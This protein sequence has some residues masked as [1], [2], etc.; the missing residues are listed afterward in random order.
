MMLLMLERVPRRL[1]GEL[2]RWLLEPRA[3]LFIGN[4]SA[5][6]REKLW[7]MACLDSAGGSVFLVYTTNS[8]QGFT[9]R[10]WGEPSYIPEDFEGILLVRRPGR[11]PAVDNITA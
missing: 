4:V 3:N 5:M 2:T 6:V 8:E 7:E 9:W 11:K 1:R 10:V